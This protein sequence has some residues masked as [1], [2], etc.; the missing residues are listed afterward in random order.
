MRCTEQQE[1]IPDQEL[2]GDTI[3]RNCQCKK[4]QANN[5]SNSFMLGKFALKTGF[6]DQ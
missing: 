2:Q 3:I 6:K 4:K 1:G 5:P